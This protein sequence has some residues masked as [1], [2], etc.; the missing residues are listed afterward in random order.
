MVGTSSRNPSLL[1]G[2]SSREVTFMFSCPFWSCSCRCSN[3]RAPRSG[4]KPRLSLGPSRSRCCLASLACLAYLA[5]LCSL[6]P[7]PSLQASLLQGEY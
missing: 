6:N 4:L 1:W 2:P 7:L 5:Y 3:R